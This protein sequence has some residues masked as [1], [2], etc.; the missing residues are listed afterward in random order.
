MS[1][2]PDVPP[3]LTAES[4]AQIVKD[5]ID[6]DHKWLEFAKAQGKDD[7]DYFKHIFDRTYWFV[8]IIVAVVGVAG[9]VLGV[10]S[11]SQIRERAETTV[12]AEVTKVEA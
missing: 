5:E 9:T 12:N 1:D 4:V 2:K 3:P 7:R 8:A 6:R 10:S 11:I